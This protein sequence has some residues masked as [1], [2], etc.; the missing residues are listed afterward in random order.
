MSTSVKTKPMPQFPKDALCTAVLHCYGYPEDT[1][2]SFRTG[3]IQINYSLVGVK[4]TIHLV[5]NN[6]KGKYTQ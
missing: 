4:A 6:K 1:C 2:S 3:S 5:G